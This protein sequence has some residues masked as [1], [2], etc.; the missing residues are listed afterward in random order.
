MSKPAFK[1]PGTAQSNIA[2]VT[3]AWPT[4]VSGDLA[5]LFVESAN[6]NITLST[7]SGFVE[8][9]S[10]TGTGTTAGASSTRIAVFWCR[11]T[12]GAMASPVV[13]DAGDHV[14]AQIYTYSGVVSSGTPYGDFSF[15]TKTPAAANTTLNS[16][17]TQRDD[18][19]VVLA[20]TRSDDSVS[21]TAFSAW[22][23]ANLT[24]VTERGEAGTTSGNGGGFGVA[25]GGKT[26]AGATGTSSVTVLSTVSAFVT[27]ELFG[28]TL[29]PSISENVTLTESNQFLTESNLN[30]SESVAV[31]ENQVLSLNRKL[32]N[33]NP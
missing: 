9:P 31:S 7:A 1:N 17:T 23:N 4:H 16:I 25:D 18:S 11:A 21:T 14:V 27:I 20:A 5:L 15:G 26:T 30:K 10:Q 3:P 8:I 33:R 2:S 12:S 32:A 24:S 22:T 29:V 19:L 13:A 6:E 28:N